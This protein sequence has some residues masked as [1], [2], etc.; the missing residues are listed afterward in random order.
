MPGK[1]TIMI[2]EDHDLFRS[3]LK[4]AVDEIKNLELAGEAENG[5]VFLELLKENRPDIIL[6]DIK[7]PV[8]DGIE[9]TEQALK[10]DPSLK[11]IALTIFGEEE[12]LYT[13]I[14]KG[15]SG[16]MLKSTSI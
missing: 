3:G 13:M 1:I 6:M 8:M 11:I 2:V 10:I 7:M 15:I 5:A 9:A 4:R 12:F 16:F 14:Q